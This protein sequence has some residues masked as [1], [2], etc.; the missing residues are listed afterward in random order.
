[1]C[2]N[3]FHEAIVNLTQSRIE[4]NLRLGSN[5]HGNVDAEEIVAVENAIL[6]DDDV[7]AEIAKL[8]LPEGAVVICDPWTYGE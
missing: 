7:Q 2:K 1:M 8:K 3:K 6:Q 4:Q 5:Q